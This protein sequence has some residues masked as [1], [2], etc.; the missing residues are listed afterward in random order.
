MVL[1]PRGFRQSQARALG[2]QRQVRVA[3]AKERRVCH[4]AR[5]VLPDG[6]TA[7]VANLH[8]T[9]YWPDQRLPDAELLRA[10]E[11]A[12]SLARP[13]EL[14]VLA[15]DFNVEVTRSRTLADLA[16]GDWAFSAGGPHIDH[17]LVRD[18]EVTELEVWAEER[19]RVDGVLVSDHAPVELEVA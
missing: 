14:V 10:A 5:V 18:A 16:A 2:L 15:G 8:A 9:S 19:R 3:W 17:V 13:G 7:L 6:R 11:F 4:A 12:R 1:N